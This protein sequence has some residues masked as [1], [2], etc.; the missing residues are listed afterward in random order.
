M[1]TLHD[2]TGRIVAH[3]HA[4]RVA[5]EDAIAVLPASE[6]AGLLA[7]ALTAAYGGAVAAAILAQ[8]LFETEN[9]K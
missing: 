3:P 7:G 2:H 1:T 8:A 5:L 6:A 9:G 4:R